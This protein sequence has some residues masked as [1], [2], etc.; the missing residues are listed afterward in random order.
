MRDIIEVLGLVANERT[1][2]DALW[3]KEDRGFPHID[4]M[5]SLVKFDKV[6]TAKLYEIPTAAR[7]KQ[8]CEIAFSEGRGS[9]GH[10]L[11]EE[12][13]EAIEAAAEASDDPSRTEHLEEE[14]IQVAAVAVKWVQ[15]IRE[16]EGR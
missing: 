2:Q 13:C 4:D 11:V 12:I 5:L 3:G 16:R 8:L 7:A 9:L 1:R 15:I 10:I 14:L 6:A